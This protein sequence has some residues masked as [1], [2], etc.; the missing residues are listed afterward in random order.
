M[1]AQARC[2]VG[3]V[4]E[5][6]RPRASGVELISVDGDVQHSLII[7]AVGAAVRFMRAK[8]GGRSQCPQMTAAISVISCISFDAMIQITTNKRSI[9]MISNLTPS[10]QQ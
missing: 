2:P 5:C 6:G 1:G 9:A 8:S 3:I 4:G 7:F 10:Y